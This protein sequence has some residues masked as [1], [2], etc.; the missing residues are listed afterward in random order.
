MISIDYRLCE[1]ESAGFVGQMLK[2]IVLF[3]LSI[4]RKTY[5]DMLDEFFVL[6]IDVV[7]GLV[8]DALHEKLQVLLSQSTPVLFPA[9]SS[10]SVFDL[11]F[12][13]FVFF[14][15]FQI[16]VVVLGICEVTHYSLL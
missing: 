12:M 9:K 6:E 3:A 13:I 2:E 10:N 11:R 4:R 14:Y 1:L 5:F 8:P 16:V 7:V 15:H